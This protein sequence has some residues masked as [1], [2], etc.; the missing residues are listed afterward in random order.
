MGG[1]C[2]SQNTLGMDPNAPLAYAPGSE[3]HHPTM[4][5]LGG[6]GGQLDR[7]IER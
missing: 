5:V 3:L 2:S 6:H 1:Y 4:S 7:D